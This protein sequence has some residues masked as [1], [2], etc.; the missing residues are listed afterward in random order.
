MR[1][2]LYRAAF[3]PLLMLVSLSA[4]SATWVID[5]D[6]SRVIFKYSYSGT[7]YQ[8]AFTNIDAEFDIDPMNPTACDF[9]VTIHIEDID[10][11]D[12]ETLSYLLDVD[13]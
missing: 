2:L 11:D 9:S 10:I 6:D 13:M 8:G 4:Q 7:P 3:A 5:P 12:E 1:N